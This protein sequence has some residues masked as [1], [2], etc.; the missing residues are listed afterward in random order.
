MDFDNCTCAAC[1]LPIDMSPRRKHVAVLLDAH[2]DMTLTAISKRVGCT[3]QRVSQIKQ[4]IQEMQ[5]QAELKPALKPRRIGWVTLWEWSRELLQWA[6][7]HDYP[8]LRLPY[9]QGWIEQG[10]D[11]W[12]KYFKDISAKRLQYVTESIQVYTRRHYATEEQVKWKLP[13]SFI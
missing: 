13:P 6:E 3:R 9:K 12:F 2:P 4:R 8:C 11:S 1:I 7:Q 5:N 10:R